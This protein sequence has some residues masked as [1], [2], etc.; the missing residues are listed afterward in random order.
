MVEV[1][2]TRRPKPE[3]EPLPTRAADSSGW[4]VLC[5]QCGRSRLVWREQIMSGTWQR[6]PACEKGDASAE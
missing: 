6:C 4:Y 5:P 1:S 3:P 2:I